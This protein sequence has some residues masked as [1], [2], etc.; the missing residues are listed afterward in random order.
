MLCG[1]CRVFIYPALMAELRPFAF[2]LTVL[3]EIPSATSAGYVLPVVI[4]GLSNG[5]VKDRMRSI[6]GLDRAE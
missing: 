5:L 4:R 6:T 3:P 2:L 1:S